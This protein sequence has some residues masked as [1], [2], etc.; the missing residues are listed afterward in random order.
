M[1]SLWQHRA[2]VVLE[3]KQASSIKPLVLPSVSDSLHQ[4]DARLQKQCQQGE[5]LL[6]FETCLVA[7]WFVP[8]LFWE[9]CGVLGPK[10][11]AETPLHITHHVDFLAVIDR[12]FCQPS[13]RMYNL[14]S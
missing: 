1:V 6:S 4:A 11:K 9:T 13:A 5:K 8:L 10:S 2:L 12:F 7:V 3:I 14:F